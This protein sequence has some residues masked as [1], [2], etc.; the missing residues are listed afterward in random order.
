MKPTHVRTTGMAAA[1]LALP[2]A[3]GVL[4]PHA[5][6]DTPS[7]SPSTSMSTPFGPGC[8]SMPHSGTGSAAEM[9]KVPLAT[10]AA[11]NPELS[12]LVSAVKKAGL[13]DT[14]NKAKDSTLFAP[15]N[16]A[17]NKLGKAKVDALLNNKT[18]L[19]KVLTYHVVGKKITPSELPHGSFTTLEGGKLTTSG[20]GTSFKV[21]DT[22]AITCGD[23][24]TA[25]GKVYVIDGVLTPPS[26]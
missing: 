3:L 11:Q 6:A 25:N 13:T 9:A 10:A 21:N 16:D 5:S 17:F 12:M 8:S 7:P 2:M 19:K 22:A 26:S 20:S 24:S 1:T 18:E 14:L 4:A 15:T 23:I